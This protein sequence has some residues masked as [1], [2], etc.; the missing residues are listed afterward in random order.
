MNISFLKKL[1]TEIVVFLLSL[2]F[3][4]IIFI[5]F[6]SLHESSEEDLFNAQQTLQ[7]AKHRYFEALKKQ[8]TYVSYEKRF[9]ML[10][11]QGIFG[12]EQRLRWIDA[13]ETISLKYQIPYLKYKIEPQQE[14][15]QASLTQRYPG[16]SFRRSSM[17]L[18]LQLLHEGDLYSILKG[19]DKHAGGLFDVESCAITRNLLVGKTLIDNPDGKNFSARCTLNWYTLTKK[20]INPADM[21]SGRSG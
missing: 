11:K 2:C 4:T 12:D 1:Q 7:S 8:T 9:E 15:N 20:V 3:A 17:E 5:V 13:L 18:D 16:I 14:I 19:L 21:L 6:Y 10:N